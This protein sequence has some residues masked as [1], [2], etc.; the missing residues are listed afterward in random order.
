VV[1]P[2]NP[3][4]PAKAEAAGW[5]PTPQRPLGFSFND[6][7]KLPPIHAITCESGGQIP[8][9]VARRF[10]LVQVSSTFQ[11]QIGPRHVDDTMEMSPGEPPLP[12]V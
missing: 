7:R 10:A 11:I 12:V 8:T 1:K 6:I 4:T 3:R 2:S 9:P 5:K